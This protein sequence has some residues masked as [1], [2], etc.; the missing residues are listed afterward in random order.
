M[1]SIAAAAAAVDST[2]AAID[3]AV[4]TVMAT[5]FRTKD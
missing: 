1:L 5:A 2:L 3:K 4:H